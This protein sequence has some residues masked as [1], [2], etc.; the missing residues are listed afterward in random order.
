MNMGVLS[1]LEPND[2]FRYFEEMSQIPRPSYK[3]KA[4]SDYLVAF[5]KKHGLTYYQDE[6]YNVI[7]IKE[8]TPGYEQED[9]II[10]Q[11]HMDMVCE[12]AP[13]CTKD[14]EKEGLDLY[15]DGDFIR[16]R[17]TTL[18]AD[19]GIAVAYAL[20]LLSS[21][22]LRHPR[23]EFVC[24]VSEEV[25]MEGAHGIDVSM[26]KGHTLLNIDSEEEG[27]VLASCA[28]GG[29][30]KVELP[31]ERKETRGLSL[32]LS[33]DQL[34]GG[35]SGAEIH[36]GRANATLLMVRMLT[37]LSKDFG[38]R[39]IEMEG[40]SKDNAIPRACT[41]TLFLENES[42]Q[43]ELEKKVSRMEAEM[44]KEYA[45]VDPDLCIRLRKETET[46]NSAP[47]TAEDT[48][49]ILA[50]ISALPCGVQRMSDDIRGLVETSLNLG[51]TKLNETGLTLSYAVRSS[52][53]TAFE[54]LNAKMTLISEAFG[55]KATV[56]AVYPAWEY[57]RDSKL[58][59]RM[60]RVY[61]ELFGK[62][63]R[64]EAI[65]AG[66]ECGVLAGKIPGLDAVSMGPD[67]FDIHTPNEHLSISSTKRV[68][69]FIVQLIEAK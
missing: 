43:K 55:A 63:L 59:D 2:V 36:K 16:A 56:S 26:L 53:P 57:V 69:D 27:V 30:F 38:L 46:G 66:L 48:R 17:G 64:I 34:T 65:H 19:D 37:A 13:G 60:S 33:I 8:A 50:L 58:R 11:G 25:G 10:I 51:I 22:T 29:N 45:V 14:M 62:E 1:N 67:M 61:R 32:M 41:A 20:A 18:G 54:A 23:L 15:I 35:H 42:D 12:T 3:E 44:K 21:D 4:I 24:T 5:A 47:V 40:G 28:G 39:L 7:M 52:V 49:K 31:V 6:I 9:P 68:Y